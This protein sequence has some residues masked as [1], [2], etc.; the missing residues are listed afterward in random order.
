MIS[1]ISNNPIFGK[2]SFSSSLFFTL[3]MLLFYVFESFILHFINYVF[4]MCAI[5]LLI[6]SNNKYF[7]NAFPAV[8]LHF[9]WIKIMQN[10]SSF[11]R[12]IMFLLIA[13]L[14][15]GKQLLY[16]TSIVSQKNKYYTWTLITSLFFF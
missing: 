5:V 8:L 3:K 6:K 12:N 7:L 9:N 10:S 14:Y 13:V 2:T 1:S 4:L 11:N 15:I 16:K